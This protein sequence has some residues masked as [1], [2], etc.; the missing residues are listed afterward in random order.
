MTAG[1]DW[2]LRRLRKLIASLVLLAAGI[3]SAQAQTIK[4]VAR[5]LD[6]PWSL[7]FLPD[8]GFLVTERVGA[9]RRVS[10]QGVIS[11]PISGV[12]DVMAQGQGGLFDVV[13]SPDFDTSGTIFLSYVYGDIDANGTALMRARL[14][15]MA[16]AD[17]ETIFRA[18]PKRGAHHFG[19][20]I[21][22]MADGTLLL[23]L[24]DGF[25]YRENA[26][27][28]ADHLGT[29]VR[30]NPDGSAPDDNPFVGEAGAVPEIWSFGHRNV[31]AILVDPGSGR[32]W[33]NEHGPRGG[34]EINIVEPGANYGWP[35]VTDGLDYSGARISPWGL[36]RAA[37]FGLVQPVHVWTPSIAPAGMTL[38]DGDAFPEWRGNLF[39]AALAGKALHRLTLDGGRVV[40]EEILLADLGTRIRDVRTGP[41]GFLYL[42]T[43]ES[44]GRLLRLRPAD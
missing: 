36:D 6:H 11:E 22:F 3:V 35:I 20:R 39:V 13:L 2:P 25:A 8:G 10:P 4:E 28:R 7:A 18:S 44:D 27:N 34:D 40:D 5:G 15:G 30:L 29:I 9:L 41:D 17:P 23:T 14:D 43:D 42:L 32:V 26:Q 16:L 24:G 19:G 21:S 38:Y 1:E 37:E 12:P 33:T 31:Q